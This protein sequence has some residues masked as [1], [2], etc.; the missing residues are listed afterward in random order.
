MQKKYNTVVFLLRGQ[1]IHNVHIEIIEQ[2][3]ALADNVIVIVGSANQPRT[4]KNPFTAQERIYLLNQSIKCNNVCFRQNID[5]IYN[6]QA[7]V[8][9][10]QEIVN[11]T[12]PSGKIGLIGHDKDE[13]TYYLKSFPQWERIDVPTINEPLDATAIRDLYFRSNFNPRF[14]S[15]VVPQEV[16]D[17]MMKFKD[18]DDYRQIIREREFIASYKKQYESLPYPPIFVTTDAVVVQSGHVL[19][20][21]RKAE[22][23]RG[24][25]ALPG[26]F[27]NADTDKSTMAGMLREL[28]E[29]TK[30]D[31]PLPVLIGN[32]KNMQ[33][34]DH[35]NRSARGRTITHAFYIVLPDGKL[36][37]VKGSDD[38]LVAKWV[39]IGQLDSSECFEDHFELIS[40]FIGN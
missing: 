11:D 7:W 5:T 4:Y 31:V 26:G 22:P 23:G 37:K 1:P 12:C 20:I 39:P 40:T 14:I 19:L 2:A 27:L 8:I 25:W 30:I 13:S 33:V 34:F 35:P 21:K 28:K 18:T 36:P 15:N 6:D 17:F 9:R 16:L 38:A 32:I 24:L 29:E 10:V 3:S